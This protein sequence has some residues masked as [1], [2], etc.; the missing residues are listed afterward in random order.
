MVVCFIVFAY[1]DS[2]SLMLLGFFFLALTTG[3]NTTLPNAF[4]AEF[5]GTRNLGSIKAMAA[6]VMVL[7]S[8]IGPGITGLGIDLGMGIETQ[9]LWVAA[10]FVFASVMMALG[11]VR[12]RGNLA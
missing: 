5:F 2:Y 6:A 10:Y 7:G 11:V 1:A 9:Y 3:A 12:Y 4:W 8:A